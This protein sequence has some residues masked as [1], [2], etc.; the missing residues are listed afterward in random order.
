M[1]YV[2]AGVVLV[3]VALYWRSASSSAGSTADVDE[4]YRLC[5]GDKEQMERLIALEMARNDELSREQAAAAAVY[6]YKRD[7]R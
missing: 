7:N 2:I 6:A 5:N 1:I 3:V 4:L